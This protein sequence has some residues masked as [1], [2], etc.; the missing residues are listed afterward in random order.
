MP[1]TDHGVPVNVMNIG[2]LDGCLCVFAGVQ[3]VGID[4]WVMKEYGTKES[5]KKVFSI[6]SYD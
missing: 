5:W 1:H 3:D 4:V 2:V 6:S